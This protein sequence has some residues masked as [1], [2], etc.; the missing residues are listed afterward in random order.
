MAEIKKIKAST[1]PVAT[2]TVGFNALGIRINGD[3]TVD[4][5]LVPYSLLIG[6]TPVI[7]PSVNANGELII[8]IDYQKTQQ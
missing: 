5:V 2:S 6:A 7:T 3:G 4:N 8:T 1:L